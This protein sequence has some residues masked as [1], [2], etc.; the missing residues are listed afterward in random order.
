MN[1]EQFYQTGF[2]SLITLIIGFFLG[3]I[4]HSGNSAIP[5]RQLQI[6]HDTI[7]IDSDSITAYIDTP[8]IHNVYAEL[9]KQNIKHP[10]IVLAQSI[11]ETGY[12]Q[13]NVC[14][15]NNNLFGLMKGND[16]HSFSHWKQSV[17]YYKN[18]VQSRYKGG[19]YYTF[20]SDIGYAIDDDYIKK[21]K[22]LV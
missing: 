8:S 7:Y 19:D 14:K 9:K 11:L 10:K 5:E 6:A 15:N 12:Y 18:H 2:Y 1:K 4:Y 22:Q 20:L 13:S 21:L 16:Y 17:T 3:T